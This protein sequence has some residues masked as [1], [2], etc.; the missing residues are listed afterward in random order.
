MSPLLPEYIRHRISMRFW[1]KLILSV[2]ILFWMVPEILTS[3]QSRLASAASPCE[4][5][6]ALPTSPSPAAM[7]GGTSQTEIA[8]ASAIFSREAELSQSS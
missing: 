6:L 2:A 5:C 1:A 8:Q 7:S 4:T 3:H